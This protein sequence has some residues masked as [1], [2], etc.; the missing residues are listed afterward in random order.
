MIIRQ[1]ARATGGRSGTHGSH[2]AAEAYPWQ[3]DTERDVRRQRTAEGAYPR[4]ANSK[5]GAP[6]AIFTRYIYILKYIEMY[7][8]N[9]RNEARQFVTWLGTRSC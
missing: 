6:T 5:R 2:A 8:S 3:G 7:R 4:D 9:T 1:G